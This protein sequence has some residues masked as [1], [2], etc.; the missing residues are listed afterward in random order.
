MQTKFRA[1]TKL[2]II[3]SRQREFS[4]ITISRAGRVLRHIS[5]AAPVVYT[6]QRVGNRFQRIIIMLKSRISGQL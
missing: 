3:G 6:L 1:Y 4:I 5:A 2:V